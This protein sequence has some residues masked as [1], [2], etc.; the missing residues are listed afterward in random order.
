M[1]TSIPRKLATSMARYAAGLLPQPRAEWGEAMR[2]EVDHIASDFKA[3][4]W[5]TG[6]VVAAFFERN[7][8][9]SQ[10]FAKIVKRPSAFLP[11][12]MSLV[13]LAVVLFTLAIFGVPH[14]KD[15]GAAAHIW[16][17]LMAGQLPLL[18][19][20]AVKWLPRAPKETLCV[21]ALQ[22]AAV[23]AAMAPVYFLHL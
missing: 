17:L 4:T 23:L 11:L 12:A 14:D 7:A 6:C 1:R 22:M 3:M 9:R 20:F 21:I 19:F 8:D 2:N 10:T 5:A 13:A 15:E 16:Q 18:V